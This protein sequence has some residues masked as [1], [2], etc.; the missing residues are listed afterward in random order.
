MTVDAILRYGVQ[1]R[2]N[3]WIGFRNLTLSGA[4]THASC[5]SSNLADHLFI[6]LLNRTLHPNSSELQWRETLKQLIDTG[7]TVSFLSSRSTAAIR[8]LACSCAEWEQ[9]QSLPSHRLV[10]SADDVV[11]VYNHEALE[12][13]DSLQERE[14]LPARRHLQVA[15][16]VARLAPP[17]AAQR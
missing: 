7:L 17:L 4:P 6:A 14:V 10:E 15:P 11:D 2:R 1:L 13:N 12:C 8:H 9:V 5:S 3:A 16:V